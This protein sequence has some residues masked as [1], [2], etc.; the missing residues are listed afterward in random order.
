[1]VNVG[2]YTV[3]PMDPM[4]WGYPLWAGPCYNNL[5]IEWWPMESLWWGGTPG[6]LASVLLRFRKP[7]EFGGLEW[8]KGPILLLTLIRCFVEKR[9]QGTKKKLGI[10]CNRLSFR[11][12]GAIPKLPST[13]FC[14]W[15]PAK[16]IL[17]VAKSKNFPKTEPKKIQVTRWWFQL[18]FIFTPTWGSD[19]IWLIFFNWVETTN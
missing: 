6:V 7:G 14:C 4:G 17:L 1:M 18:F 2:K 19:P 8:Q 5:C 10:C 12:F 15:D 16:S 3:R 13:I 11:F 9:S